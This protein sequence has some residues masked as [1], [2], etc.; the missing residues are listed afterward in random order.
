MLNRNHENM[1]VT[2][3]FGLKSLFDG[4]LTGIGD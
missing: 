4:N 3:H 1:L 2:Y